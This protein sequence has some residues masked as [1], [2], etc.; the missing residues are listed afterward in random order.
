MLVYQHRFARLCCVQLKMLKLFLIH[1]IYLY[2]RYGFTGDLK[3]NLIFV[4]R[5]EIRLFEMC[6][7]FLLVMQFTYISRYDNGINATGKNQFQCGTYYWVK[8]NLPL[9][10]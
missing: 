1:S 6:G 7:I 10:L 2:K 4:R 5:I 8:R 9:V 3:L